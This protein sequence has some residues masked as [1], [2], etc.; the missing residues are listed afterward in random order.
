MSA[1]I[2]AYLEQTPPL[3][4]AMTQSFEDRNWELLHAA[5]HK[6][7][8]SFLIM[9]IPNDFEVMAKKVMDYAKSQQ[10]MEN[11]SD[12]VLQLEDVCTRAC[13]ELRAELTHF[14]TT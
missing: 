13:E 7:I 1:M 5:V 4:Q 10:E 6:M 8:P 3:I 11:M 12:F 14:K 2:D 9:G